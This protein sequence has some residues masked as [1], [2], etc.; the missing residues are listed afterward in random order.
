MAK[1]KKPQDIYGILNKASNVLESGAAFLTAS[2]PALIMIM[3]MIEANKTA[4]A[5]AQAQAEPAVITPYQTL[6][7]METAS[8][9][10]ISAIYRTKAKFYHPDK[11]GNPET[12]KMIKSAYEEIKKERGF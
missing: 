1:S 7:V 12:F 8:N 11:G 5:Q 2:Q 9:E 4:K 3:G 6:G 10:E